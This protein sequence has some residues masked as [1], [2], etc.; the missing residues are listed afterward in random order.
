MKKIKN[1]QQS[2]SVK[3]KIEVV[4][5]RASVQYLGINGDEL[6]ESNPKYVKA[7]CEKIISG[8]GD[9]S[10]VFGRDRNYDRSSGY[11]GKGHTKSNSIDIVVGR[12]GP[13]IITGNEYAEPN[14]EL[15]ACRVYVSQ[16][17]DPDKYFKIVDGSGS[18]V[19]ISSVGLKADA[20]R[21][22]SRDG[23]IKLVTNVDKVNSRGF[24]INKVQGVDIIAG[25][26]DTYLQYTPAG[27]NMLDLIKKLIKHV[28]DLNSVVDTVV[29]VQSDYDK[30]I[31]NHYHMSPFFGKPTTP[32][33][34]CTQAGIQTVVNLMLKAKKSLISHKMNLVNLN[35]NYCSPAGSKYALSRYNKI[36]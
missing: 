23:G 31:A 34:Q 24:D 14:F 10:I 7:N 13:T 26:D 4:D 6:L 22:I 21:I 28:E 8:T 2:D 25:N 19:G 5:I 30:V 27:E 33:L 15:D 32:S 11:G 9:A 35:Y 17:S 3:S 16:K 36:N 18:H 20:V 29:T 1:V 12:L